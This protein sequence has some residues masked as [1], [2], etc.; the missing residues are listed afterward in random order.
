MR[1]D[2]LNS[3]GPLLFET[4]R[5]RCRHLMDLCKANANETTANSRL[6]QSEIQLFNVGCNTNAIVCCRKFVICF[7]AK[8]P[9]YYY[10]FL[11]F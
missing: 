9:N 8:L 2:R 4:C 11:V 3:V 1:F 10:F 6:E 5:Q 7:F